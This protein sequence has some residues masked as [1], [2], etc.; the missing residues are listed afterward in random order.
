MKY[1]TIRFLAP[2]LSAAL[3]LSLLAGCGAA[4]N[5]AGS[6]SAGSSVSSVTETASASSAASTAAQ[7]LSADVD[8]SGA[9]AITLSGTSAA[10]SGSGASAEGGVVTITDG[11]TYV[12]TGTLTEG[13][14][15]VDAKGEDVTIV[16]NGASI[17][18]SYG[19]PIYIYKS[20]STTIHLAEG[21]ENDLTDGSSYTFAD[22]YSSAEDEE[23]NACLYSKSDLI[24]QGTGSLTVTANYNNGITSKDTLTITDAT[25]TVNAVNHGI[26]GKDSAA[27]SNATITVMAKGDAIRSTN[28]SDDSLGWITFSGGTYV[29]TSGDDA[30]H[31]ITLVQIDGGDFTITAAEGIEATYVRINDGTIYIEASDDGINAARKSD[32]Y[33]PT[34]EING[35]EITIVM[36]AGDTDGIDSNGNIVVN[37]GTISVTGNSTFDYDGTATYNGGTIIVNGQQVDSIPNQFMGGMGGMGGWGGQQGG[38]QQG[39]WGGPGGRR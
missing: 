4:G 3:A 15:I 37:G 6:A 18:C 31:A 39:G 16:L 9:T 2:A 26:N 34:V 25:I 22:S 33:T 1:K 17:T 8:V 32:A 36:G 23:P 38:Q 27:I 35:G 13:R 11:G 28:E 10:V 14:I 29:L 30:I 19:S 5:T 24:I 12:V 7:S 20:S 21:S